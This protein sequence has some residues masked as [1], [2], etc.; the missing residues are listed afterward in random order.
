MK[1]IAILG[2]SSQISRDYILWKSLHS[3][4]QLYLFVRRPR[5]MWNWVKRQGI[6]SKVRIEHYEDFGTHNEYFAIINFVG[7]GDPARALAMGADVLDLTHQYDSLAVEYLKLHSRCRYLFMSSGAAYGRCFEAPVSEETCAGYY[8]NALEQQD[9]YGMAKA[10][11]E[12]RHRAFD[13]LPILDIRIFNYVSNTL[14]LNARFLLTDAFRAIRNGT[15]LATSSERTVRDY[16]HSS[17]LCSLIDAALSAPPTNDVID[18][19][20]RAPIDKFEMLKALNVKHGLRYQV[21]HLS[22]SLNPT[23]TKPYYYSLNRRAHR[24]GYQPKLTSLGGILMAASEIL[25]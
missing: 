5:E 16:I 3:N 4:F 13:A 9:F 11:A 10:Y 6:A 15:V 12:C 22:R 21:S 17:D 14:D 20:S 19:Y 8:L 18:C 1:N 2:A 23:G 24:F 25:N 7:V